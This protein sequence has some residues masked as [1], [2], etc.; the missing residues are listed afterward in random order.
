MSV[1]LLVT[2]MFGG[3]AMFIFLICCLVLAVLPHSRQKNKFPLFSNKFS[4][5]ERRIKE[6]NFY[7]ILTDV[8]Q[9]HFWFDK[10]CYKCYKHSQG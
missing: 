5:S 1:V 7:G 3:C 9:G 4:S 6:L 8:R 2:D 10:T